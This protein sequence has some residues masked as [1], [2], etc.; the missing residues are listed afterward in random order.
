MKAINISI[1]IAFLVDKLDNKFSI[2]SLAIM[3]T[4]TFYIYYEDYICGPDKENY[5]QILFFYKKENNKKKCL[6]N[7]V[8]IIL[9]IALALVSIFVLIVLVEKMGKRFNISIINNMPTINN[10]YINFKMVYLLIPLIVAG[11]FAIIGTYQSNNNK[12]IKKDMRIRTLVRDLGE[13]IIIPCL[14]DLTGSFSSTAVIS[15][16]F[17]LFFIVWGYWDEDD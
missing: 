11:A 9:S 13:I 10:K 6:T 2:C 1:L 17:S 4:G 16:L 8:I 3:F 15:T 5:Y 14:M 7:I 12:L